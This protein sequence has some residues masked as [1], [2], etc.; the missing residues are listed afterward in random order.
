M[1]VT[2]AALSSAACYTLR[3][4][5]FE[6]LSV[7]RPSAVWITR[8]DQSVVIVETPR[9]FGDTLVGYING[10][11]QEVDAATLQPK[12]YRVKRMAGARTAGLVVAGMLGVGTFA[13]L[14][15]STGS[16]DDP[17]TRM[18]CEDPQTPGCPQANPI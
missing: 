14:A 15:S 18:D 6:Q 1:W 5:T 10:E 17:T 2:A 3:P 8:A 7:A 4:V 11:F 13:F 9:V 12:L 16:Y